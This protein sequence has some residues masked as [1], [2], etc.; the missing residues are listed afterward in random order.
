MKWRSSN[1]YLIKESDEIVETYMLGDRC[2]VI[3]IHKF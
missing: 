1:L 3:T 2:I